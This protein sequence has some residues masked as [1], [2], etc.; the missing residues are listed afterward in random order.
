MGI[1]RSTLYSW[2]KRYN[3]KRLITLA[4]ILFPRSMT[5]Y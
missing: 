5:R 2:I 4:F 3:S 1:S